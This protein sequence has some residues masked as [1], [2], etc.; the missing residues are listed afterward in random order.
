MPHV[1]HII[2]WALITTH[3]TNTR[4]ATPFHWIFIYDDFA[5]VF[6]QFYTFF[7]FWIQNLF[8]FVF[9]FL[10]YLLPINKYWF[11]K[12][13]CLFFLFV[14]VVFFVVLM[15]MLLFYNLF[16]MFE[17]FT[18]ILY[19]FVLFVYMIDLVEL[20]SLVSLSPISLI[21]IEWHF[22]YVNLVEVHLGFCFILELTLAWHCSHQSI[23]LHVLW[24]KIL[25][26]WIEAF[27]SEDIIKS[28]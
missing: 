11:W 5:G 19:K 17:T 20:E 10:S 12:F 23:S 3:F 25:M 14:V 22:N 15:M 16:Y 6:A 26:R 9:L 21:K 18:H 1:M 28:L 4:E 2:V 8:F 24:I 27:W 13:I 7:V